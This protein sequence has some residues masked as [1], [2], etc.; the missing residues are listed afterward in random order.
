MPQSEIELSFVNFI[1]GTNIKR[2]TLKM[3]KSKVGDHIEG[4][5]KA[6]FSIATTPMYRGGC[7]SIPRIAPLYPW[8]L[9]YNEEC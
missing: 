9:P 2:E 8:S 4:D 6:P 5:Q 3:E 7:Y 1:F